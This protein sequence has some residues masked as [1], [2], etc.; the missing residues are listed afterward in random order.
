MK[1]IEGFALPKNQSLYDRARAVLPGGVNASARFNPALQ[2]PLFLERGEG[3]YIYDVDGHRYIDYCVSHGASLLGHGNPAV[4]AAVREALER[5]LLLA[6][7]TDIQVQV[8]EQLLRLFPGVDMVRY[9][10]SGTET[11]WHA[12]RVARAFTG[13][14]GVVKFEGHY[15]GVND[16]VGFS[17]WPSLEKAG[18]AEAPRPV[19]DS[20]GI[21]PASAELITILPFNDVDV[22]EECLRTRAHDLAAVIMEPINYDSGGIRPTPEFLHAVRELTR[23]LGIVLVFDEVLSGFRVQLGPALG[24]EVVPDLTVLGK[25]VGGG[26]PISAFLGRREIMETCT[27]VGP[28]LHSGTYNAPPVLVAAMGAFLQEAS[29]PGF[30]EHLHRLGDRLYNGLREI[31]ERRGI[32]AWVQGVG[33]RFGLLFGLDREPRNYRDVAKQDLAQMARFHLACLRRGVYLHHVSPHHGFSSAHTLA[34]IE[35]TLDVMDQAA[36]ELLRK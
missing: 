9:A 27:P 22:L 21:P 16:T 13:K 35:E 12:L 14:W 34:D 23:E 25:A 3:A 17:H 5:G 19:P 2:G 24:Q 10:C 20:A 33:A 8:A 1:S 26:M 30:Y 28:A 4:V 6:Y 29:R 7:E 36:Q 15:H 11:T 32:K 31:M 18:P